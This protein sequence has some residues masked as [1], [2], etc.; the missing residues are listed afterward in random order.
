MEEPRPSPDAAVEQFENAAAADARQAVQSGADIPIGSLSLVEGDKYKPEPLPPRMMYGTAGEKTVFRTNYFAMALK[1]INGQRLMLWGYDVA[2]SPP[3]DKSRRKKRQL[4]AMLL[5]DPVFG[6]IPAAT[7]YSAIVVTAKKLDFGNSKSREFPIV[8][9]DPDEPPF[10]APTPGEPP[11]RTEA[12][13]RRKKT[14]KVSLVQSYD[15]QDLVDYLV[16]PRLSARFGD[17]D[18]V[19]AVVQLLNIVTNKFP[20]TLP[21]V[22]PRNQN[23]FYPIRRPRSLGEGVEALRGYFS[24]VRL[25]PTRL[26]LNV[27]VCHSAF[28]SPVV[29]DQLL[30]DCS[31]RRNAQQRSAGEYRRLERFLKMVRIRTHYRWDIDENGNI[32]KDDQGNERRIIKRFTIVGFAKQGSRVG[33]NAREARVRW[34]DSG[35]EKTDTVE[36]FFLNSK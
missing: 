20:N 21:N 25:G 34:K 14:L 26:L 3:E 1:S 18:T 35:V 31:G 6:G 7:D 9:H 11:E 33:L 30:Y 8:Y 32:K 29:L 19:K 16:S 4:L 15:I 10:P 24:S 27:N 12:R 23:T 17:A 28:Y 2:I 22:T 13:N 36:S 5:D